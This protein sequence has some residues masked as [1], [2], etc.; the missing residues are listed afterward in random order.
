MTDPRKILRTRPAGD[1]HQVITVHVRGPASRRH[2]KRP[3]ADC[4]WRVDATGVFP[5]EA[6]RHSAETAYDMATHTFAC[7]QA[8]E[9]RSAACAGFL[10][11]GADHNMKARMQRMRGHLLQVADGGHELHSCYASMAIANG[12]SPEDP[13]LAPCRESD[14]AVDLVERAK[15]V[16]ELAHA[17]QVDLAGAPYIKHVQRVATRLQP[18]PDAVAVAW[19][20]DVLEDHP[21]H[22]DAVLGFPPRIV[23]AVLA[24][25]RQPGQNLESYYAQVKA[26]P[27]ALRVK[28]ADVA[29]NSDPVRLALLPASTAAWAWRKYAKARVALGLETP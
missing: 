15:A 14:Y 3:C 1:Q 16:A 18:D 4:P 11:R 5:A 8:G 6:F 25:T 28:A 9:Q 24:I 19:L 12:V 10:L 21:S 26:N 29:D 20:H 7:H 27:L 23:A 22:R 2:T 17:D 13:V